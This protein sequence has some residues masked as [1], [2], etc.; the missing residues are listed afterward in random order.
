MVTSTQKATNVVTG[1]SLPAWLGTVTAVSS[2]GQ[3]AYGLAQF[4]AAS[5]A[6]VSVQ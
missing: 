1:V 2:G 6:T 3:V 5:I 4:S